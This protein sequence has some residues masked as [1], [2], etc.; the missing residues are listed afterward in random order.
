M[1]YF[2][3]NFTCNMAA[4]KYLLCS[5]IPN[6]LTHFERWHFKLFIHCHVSWDTL[7]IQATVMFHGTPCHKSQKQLSCFVGHPV[8]TRNCLVSSDIMYFQVTVMFRGTPCT[9]KQLSCFV[10]HPVHAS[11]CHVSWDTLYIL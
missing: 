2:E 11:N 1:F 5:L 10:R 3:I 8:Q 9:Y 6:N 7:Y 4:L